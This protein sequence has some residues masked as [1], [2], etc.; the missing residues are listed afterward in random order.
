MGLIEMATGK[1]PYSEFKDTTEIYKNVLQG[2]LP[3][4]IQMVSDPCLKSLIMGCIVPSSSRYTAAQCLDHHFFHPDVICTGDCIPRECVAVYP[5]NGAPP[6][7]MELSIVSIIDNIVVFQMLL[8]ATMKFIKFEY[9]LNT[10]TVKKICDEL[11]AEKI[12]D[13]SAVETF[14]S[15]LISGLEI[16]EMK[17]SS[18]QVHDGIIEVNSN[19]IGRIRDVDMIVTTSPEKEDSESLQSVNF[20]ADTIEEMR[21]IEENIKIAEAKKEL[22]KR[23][24]EE[25][26]QKLKMKLQQKST[27]PPEDNSVCSLELGKSAVKF[28][29]ESV[30]QKELY[31]DFTFE[32]IYS[33][34]PNAPQPSNVPC[35]GNS[36]NIN[37]VSEPLGSKL[38][39]LKVSPTQKCRHQAECCPLYDENAVCSPTKKQD[40]S[41]DTN[42]YRLQSSNRSRRAGNTLTAHLI[43]AI[44]HHTAYRGAGS[45]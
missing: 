33:Q 27:T 30:S 15:L 11:L 7:D 16:V 10:D 26:T 9:D 12:V 22:E 25:I 1:T 13:T 28:K 4:A 45:E 2:I 3:K 24:E 18:G 43:T 31:A 34:F 39:D 29:N 17:I 44:W 40:S 41:G 32:D 36:G 6:K 19:E 23:R 20:G 35:E 14:S 37:V 8:Y 42:A 38:G 5:L 21:I